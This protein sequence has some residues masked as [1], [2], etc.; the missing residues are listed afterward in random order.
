MSVSAGHQMLLKQLVLTNSTV[1]VSRIRSCIIPNESRYQRG[2]ST[3]TSWWQHQQ[4]VICLGQQKSN[5]G[6]AVILVNKRVMPA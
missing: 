2:A 3:T 4:P 6:Y 5:G 1:E